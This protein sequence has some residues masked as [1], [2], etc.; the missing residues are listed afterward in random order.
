MN[1]ETPHYYLTS[2]WQHKHAENIFIDHP[3]SLISGA[4]LN[5][6]NICL[7]YLESEKYMRQLECNAILQCKQRR[8]MTV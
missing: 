3:F 4:T 5:G 8:E 2:R 1:K 6:F 7:S